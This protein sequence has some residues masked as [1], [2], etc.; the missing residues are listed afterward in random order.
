MCDTQTSVSGTD[1]CIVTSRSGP[2]VAVPLLFEAPATFAPLHRFFAS[3]RQRQCQPSAYRY[4]CIWRGT[5]PGDVK[6]T[7]VL[8]DH[9]R[10]ARSGSRRRKFRVDGFARADIKDDDVGRRRAAVIYSLRRAVRRSMCKP[11]ACVLQPTNRLKPLPCISPVL[12]HR[13][14]H[15]ARPS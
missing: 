4:G 6:R 7:P 1:T 12:P 8:A 11:G 15:C 2:Q 3:G 10:I 13:C 14:T 5:M 9:D